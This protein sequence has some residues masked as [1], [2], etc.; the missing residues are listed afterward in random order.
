MNAELKRNDFGRD[1]A[2]NQ[3]EV[4]LSRVFDL[5]TTTPDSIKRIRGLVLSLAI[6][7]KLTG[8]VQ[9]G[10]SVEAM[11]SRI[12]KKKE[13]DG[14][15]RTQTPLKSIDL[16]EIPFEIPATWKWVRLGDVTN[17]G[18]TEKRGEVTDTTWVLDLEDIEKDTSKILQRKTFA[19]RR[20]LSAKNCFQAGDILY[21]KLRPYLNK[22]V[23]ADSSGVCTT[24][25]LPFRCYV[26]VESK[27]FL[28]VLRSPYFLEYVNRKSYGMKMPRLGTEGGRLALIPLPP[29]G[30]QRRIVARVD[31]LMRLCDGLEKNRALEAVQHVQLISALAAP[32]VASESAPELTKNWRQ[33]AEH[34]DLFLDRP[35]AVDELEQAILQ[36]AVRG[37]L[38]KQDY[39]DES[40]KEILKRIARQK[41]AMIAQGKARRGKVSRPKSAPDAPRHLPKGWEWTNVDSLCFKVTDGTHF[42]PRYVDSGFRFVSA[43]DIVGGVL[44]FDRCRLISQE[45]H[46]Q[47]YKRCN[48]EY[49]DIVISKSGSIGTVALVK[50]RSQFSLFESLA[51]LKFDKKGLCA[52]FL[53][54]ALTHACAS[55]T[56]SHIRGVG[57]KHL[58]L[59]ILRGLE[60]GLPPRAEQERIVGAFLELRTLLAQLRDRL[61]SGASLQ[62]HLADAVVRSVETGGHLDRRI[63]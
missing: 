5:V 59:D 55:L 63:M 3:S 41:G 56:A 18:S 48:P 17:F 50:E 32:L 36:L 2:L 26:A 45:E 31:E 27:Y 37:L 14:L 44:V 38:V 7:G 1:R 51:L 15:S 58:H 47:L 9:D 10:E 30:D 23:V 49:H 28:L 54:L 8:S 39:R 13:E 40:A 52:E 60:I 25:I 34:F 35:E 43:K 61:N 22:V 4:Y 19:E 42:T 46:E 16:S 62:K 57:V 53:V 6:R 20:S 24:E 11:L 12:K 21:G 33:I 29:V